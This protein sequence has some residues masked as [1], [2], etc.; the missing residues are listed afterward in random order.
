MDPFTLKLA[1]AYLLD[2]AV[3]DP[4]WLPHPVRGLG[5]AI[6]RGERTARAWVKNEVI[7]GGLLVL[8]IVAGTWLLVHGVL[9]AAG[10]LSPWLAGVAEIVLIYSCLSTKD[11]AVE[12]WPVY[13]ALK[14]G[15]LP[16]ARAKVAMI[17]GRDPAN[18]D[19]P[20]VVRAAVETIGE[21]VMDG[22]IAPLF[23]VVLGGA[24]LACLY[25][26]VN[27]LDSMIGYRS[28]RYIRFGRIAAWTDRAMNWIPAWL[29]TLF[30]AWA[31]QLLWGSGR[32]S[33]QA[34]RRDGA[35][36]RENSFI[37]E[38]AIAGAIGARLGG[39]NVYQGKEVP[40]PWMGEALKPLDPER[41]ADAIRV[42][43]LAS[44]LAAAVAVAIRWMVG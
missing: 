5:W 27:T 44:V 7:A 30:L 20:E 28:A 17:V 18:L 2:L 36:T 19:E 39:V 40:T 25:K 38:S 16:E 43:Y 26:A 22:I 10:R 24:P 31:G 13:R 15:D 37:A 9:W 34:A 3:G 29:T 14:R 32:R 12:S 35:P 21:S 33:L 6:S 4:R 8:A 11:L 41:I 23:Y 1:S 42:M